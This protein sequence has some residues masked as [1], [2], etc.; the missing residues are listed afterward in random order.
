MARKASIPRS[1]ILQFVV[2]CVGVRSKTSSPSDFFPSP[3]TN[4][5]HYHQPWILNL[6][7]E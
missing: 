4:H 2:E 3:F 6:P 1:V 5:N 7:W